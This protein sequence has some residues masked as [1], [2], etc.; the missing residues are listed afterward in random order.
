LS[1]GLEFGQ[2]ALD[3]LNRQ[4]DRD[5]ELSELEREVSVM[6]ESLYET[7]RV[8]VFQYFQ[9]IVAGCIIDEIAGIEFNAFAVSV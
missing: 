8:M 2:L 5:K 4:N 7:E 6:N 9:F 1:P 3:L